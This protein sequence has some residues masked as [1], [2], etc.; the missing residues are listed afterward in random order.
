MDKMQTAKYV[1]DMVLELRNFSKKAGL[2]FLTQLLEM[3]YHEA[4]MISNRV[5]PQR[6]DLDEENRIVAKAQ[7]HEASRQNKAG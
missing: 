3:T 7:E 1:C 4:F 6:F 5:T 2:L